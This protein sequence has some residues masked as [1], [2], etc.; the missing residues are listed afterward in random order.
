MPQRELVLSINISKPL[1][2]RC[3]MHEMDEAR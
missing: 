2:Q 3:W 1:E